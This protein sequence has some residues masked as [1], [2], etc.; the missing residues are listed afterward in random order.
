MSLLR[1][2]LNTYLRLVEKPRLARAKAPQQMRDNLERQARYFFRAPRGTQQQWQ[3]LQAAGRQVH[4][5]EVVPRALTSDAVIL[6]IHGG[7]FV[8][9]S[10]RTHAAML[11]QIADLTGMRAVL[12]RYRLAPEAPFP[13]APTDVRTAWD[14]LI[15]SGVKPGRVIVGGDSA[16]GALALGLLAE[17]AGEGAAQPAGVFCFS[18]LTDL[19]YSGESFRQNARSEAVLVADRADEM[20]RMYLGHHPATDPAVSPLFAD[21]TGAVPVWLTVGDTEIL[22][23]DSR[24]MAARLRGQGVDASFTEARDLPHVWPILH[25]TLPE[26]RSSLRELA[27]WIN[28]RLDFPGES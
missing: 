8:F 18:P 16:G 25:N 7:G 9:G 6:Y 23:D 27:G 20:G 15:A 21:F 11:G 22:R 26:A 28:Q 24:R 2:I 1:P 4:A 19:T 12:P 17:L 3:V 10:P 13:A 14:A 5:L